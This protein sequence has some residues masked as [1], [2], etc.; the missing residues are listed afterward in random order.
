MTTGKVVLDRWRE[1][2]ALFDA[3]LDRAPSARAAF[4]REACGGDEDLLRLASELVASVETAPDFL[5]D[6][7]LLVTLADE[8]D[9]DAED[10]GRRV[11][12]YRLLAPI[13]RGGTG[14]VYAAERVGGDFE[15]RL[16]VKI[17]RRGLDTADVLERFRA[18]RRILASLSHPN[19]ARLYDGGATDDGRPYLIMELVEGE[20]ITEYCDSRRLGIG[21]R[22]RLFATVCRAVQHAHRKLIVHRDIKPSNILV[23]GD[24]TPKLLDFGI[25]KLLHADPALRDTPLTRTGLRP[26]TP[27][28]ASPEQVRGD[29]ITTAVDVYQLGLLLYELVSGRR[30]Y[31]IES[32]SPQAFETAVREQDPER[33]S[34]ALRQ[35]GEAGEAGPGG[36]IVAVIATRRGTDPRRLRARLSGDIDTIVAKALRSE[37][38]QRYA[39]AADLAEDVER[40][41]DRRPVAARPATWGYR[42]KKLIRR[43]PG[44]V[45]AG[46]LISLAGI[47]YS[48]TLQL[49]A[50]ALERER[51][52]ARVEAEK[53][54]QVAGFMREVFTFS[55][56]NVT[57][58]GMVTARELLDEAARRLEVRLVEQ[59][60]VRASLLSAIARVYQEY[61]VN[62][63]ALALYTDAVSARRLV[64][65]EH[66][67]DHADDLRAI[68]FLLQRSDPA[69]SDSL[70][71]EALTL[72]ERH[73]GPSH[74][75]VGRILTDYGHSLSFRGVVPNEEVRAMYRRAIRIFRESTDDVRENL[76]HVLVISA[77]GSE[78]NPPL[79]DGESGPDRMREALELRIALLG[80]ESI[81]V[82]GS[83]SDLALAVEP[84]DSEESVRLLR[85]AVEIMDKLVQKRHPQA[86]G[87]LSNLAA[88]H[89]DRGEL[90]LAEPIFRETIA[91]YDQVD[92]NSSSK[93]YPLSHLGGILNTLGRGAEAEPLLVESLERFRTMQLGPEDIRIL[94]TSSHLATSMFLHGRFGDAERVLLGIDRRARSAGGPPGT[95][96]V[97]EALVELYDA[98]GRTGDADRYRAELEMHM[99]R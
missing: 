73:A 37:P 25:A 90:D 29:P 98:W 44:T 66:A 56:P 75:V 10:V 17:L 89:R 39:S 91:L 15:Q 81:E 34:Q 84:D 27:A 46:M 64:A 59:P 69:R 12:A 62:E 21:E 93:A 26:M 74:Q 5:E 4:L 1:V 57:K 80:E 85:R 45:A 14:T 50:Q 20:P 22:L 54:R 99:A 77:Y 11:G 16:A 82:A 94:K 71:R 65:T 95:Q 96:F 88:V 53:A 7:A 61:G 52:R 47:G 24:G 76:A 32:R 3:V 92:P 55:G 86:L 72:A 58:G 97:L 42:A 83:L 6:P 19:I 49:H 30:P 18:E 23:T 60:P 8:L 28:Y 87:M 78:A 68:A 31:R 36:D 63:R 43:R 2:N 9:C 48:A 13:G 79:L 51:D 67:A 41:L 40:H 38:E 33:P 70:Y 35:R